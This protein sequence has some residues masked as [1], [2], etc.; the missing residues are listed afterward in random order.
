[1]GEDDT[2][3]LERARKIWQ[4]TPSVSHLTWDVLVEGEDYERGPVPLVGGGESVNQNLT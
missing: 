3:S 1:M 4:T 2:D